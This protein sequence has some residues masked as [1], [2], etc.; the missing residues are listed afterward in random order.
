MSTTLPTI[1]HIAFYCRD[2]AKQEAFYTKYFGF[3][4]SRTYNAGQPNEFCMLKLG[5]VRL[6]L[7]PTDP[8]ETSKLTA[9]E[10]P[11]GFRHLA[12]D[13]EAIDPMLEAMKAD[14][15]VVDKSIDTGWGRIVFFRDLE[16]NIIELMQ[17]FKD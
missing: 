14:G 7:F 2:F 6:E 15:I 16:G 13:V 17:G 11:G 12:F 3:K 4:R 8:A 1:N 10:Q 9:G 5:N